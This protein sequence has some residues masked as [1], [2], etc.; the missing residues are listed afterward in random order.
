MK[1][2]NI[3]TIIS[4]SRLFLHKKWSPTTASH[5]CM[6]VRDRFMDIKEKIETESPFI[7]DGGA[8]TGST[9]DLFLSQYQSP[10][11]HAFE[12]IPNLVMNL[13]KKYAHNKSVIIHEKALGAETKI[14][15]FNVVNNLVS[16]SILK[17]TE[18][19]RG[20]HGVEMDI[21][22]TIEVKQTRLDDILE[23]M[24]DIL[25]LDLQ[26]YELEALKGCGQL[27]KNSKIITT[28]VEFVYL[29]EDQPLF[30]DID[31]FL[32]KKGFNLLNLYDLYTHPDGK[33]TSGDAVYL[34]N[35]YF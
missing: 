34:N 1:M 20:Y 33:L 21:E 14:V 28:E 4:C 15:P 5:G 35:R 17:P 8:N 25:K 9:I 6:A 24:I 16:S 10:I 31:V 22:Q 29:Y 13:F 11:I 30:S 3:K 27:L 26:G 32:R 23:D 19:N 12:P 18:L 2:Y 7:L